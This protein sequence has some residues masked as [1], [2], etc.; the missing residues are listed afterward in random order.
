VPFSA[1]VW[2]QTP[3]ESF[4]AIVRGQTPDAARAGAA[5]RGTA[6]ARA[7]VGLGANLGDRRVA[8]EHA[9]QLIGAERLSAIRETEPWGVV[10]QPPFLNAVAELDH[11]GGARALL[12]RLLAVEAE[13]GRVRDGTRYA[14]R[15]ID[16]DLLVYGGEQIDEPGLTVPHPLIAERL[17]VL[18]PLAELAPDLVVPGRGVV[19]A[20]LAELQSAT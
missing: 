8:I 16:L 1:I 12:E 5:S 19:S 17:F 13:L 6:A 10:D 20:L 4:S 15:T 2:G 14:P 9:A 7:Y 11:T 18:E 3:S